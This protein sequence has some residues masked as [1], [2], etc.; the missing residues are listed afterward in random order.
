MATQSLILMNGEFAL[1]QAELLADRVIRE[2]KADA[3][4]VKDLPGLPQP[5]K[6][7]WSYG[8]G[9]L[10]EASG[11]VVDFKPLPALDW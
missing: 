5:K 9:T 4:R 7:E 6:P 1:Q 8:Y 3:V 10:D 2:A 11:R